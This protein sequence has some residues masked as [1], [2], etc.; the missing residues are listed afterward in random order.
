MEYSNELDRFSVIKLGL[1][2]QFSGEWE[3]VHQS[4]V[5]VVSWRVG[6]GPNPSLEAVFLAMRAPARIRRPFATGAFLPL[7]PEKG[8]KNIIIEM[9]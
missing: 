5:D 7:S 3:D 2:S 1:T 4:E 9:R 8:T 6:R